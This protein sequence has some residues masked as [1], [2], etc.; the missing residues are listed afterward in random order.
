MI[1]SSRL[2][3]DNPQTL[4]LRSMLA[5]KPAILLKLNE[6]GNG[7]ADVSGNNLEGFYSG[8]P[9]FN[10]PR[11]SPG[12]GPSVFFSAANSYVDLDLRAVQRPN[13]VETF[14]CWLQLP[15]AFVAGGALFSQAQT[16]GMI[17]GLFVNSTTMQNY[18]YSAGSFKSCIFNPQTVLGTGV[19]HFAQVYD[20]AHVLVYVDGSV[21]ASVAATGAIGY[22]DTTDAFLNRYNGAS[23][24]N[25]VMSD[26]AL[27]AGTALNASQI[28]GLATASN[29]PSAVKA[30]SPTAYWPLSEAG[31]GTTYADS[32][33]SGNGLSGTLSAFIGRSSRSIIT[34]APLDLAQAL[35]TGG[36]VTF[37]TTGIP[38]GNSPWSEEVYILLP[39]N[40][41]AQL[42]LLLCG[43]QIS[44]GEA[45][46]WIDTTGAPFTSQGG[47][48]VVESA[49]PIA[50]GVPHQ[51]G[52]SWDGTTLKLF[53]DGVQVG[54]NGTFGAATLAS[55]SPNK[56]GSTSSP[57]NGLT[58]Y[59][60][61]Y[62]AVYP[63]ALAPARFQAHY[64]AATQAGNQPRLTAVP[65]LIRASP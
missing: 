46:L 9:T 54:S 3:G 16:G 12:G 21:V 11:L 27:W 35:G 36:A 62:G 59:L 19:H 52:A 5:D 28:A 15:S 43:N 65:D 49:S 25:L 56:F 39:A 26:A 48:R 61:A 37:G 63:S 50:L 14:A 2:G 13:T 30:L 17:C 4:L 1:G 38:T 18:V 47:A 53:V 41:T 55:G 32:S 34:T 58:P 23:N 10:Q 33:A 51:I 29:Y 24:T 8:S 64:L 42:L 31:T 20:G 44:G 45:G 6:A 60:L 40:P 57:A 7:A 22:N